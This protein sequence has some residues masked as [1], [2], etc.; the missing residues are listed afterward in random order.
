[1]YFMQE[2]LFLPL[3]GVALFLTW[4]CKRKQTIVTFITMIVIW[5][6]VGLTHGIVGL[7]VAVDNTSR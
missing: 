6:T 4:R 1:M 5:I 3:L 7:Y 2:T